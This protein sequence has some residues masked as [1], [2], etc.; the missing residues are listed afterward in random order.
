NVARPCRDVPANAV[1]ADLRGQGLERAQRATGAGLGATPTPVSCCGRLVFSGSTGG[2][3]RAPCFHP[4]PA[5]SAGPCRRVTGSTAG[6]ML[7]HQASERVDTS[8]G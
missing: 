7:L 6:S 2:A 1:Y 5:S 3:A 4:W 8:T